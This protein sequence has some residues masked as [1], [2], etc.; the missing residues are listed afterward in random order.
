MKK[1]EIRNLVEKWLTEEL[2]SLENLGY[3]TLQEC[4]E[5]WDYSLS[6]VDKHGELW[7]GVLQYNWDLRGGSAYQAMLHYVLGSSRFRRP[8]I[9]ATV[10]LY[11]GGDEE[12]EF[13]GY[14]FDENKTLHYFDGRVFD[15]EQK[16]EKP[17]SCNYVSNAWVQQK[18]DEEQ[19]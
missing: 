8:E 15:P 10:K 6:E 16:T 1:D 4:F 18:G 9:L 2:F 3:E 19:K 14:L 11:S 5:Y 12:I 7:S 13:R 17:V